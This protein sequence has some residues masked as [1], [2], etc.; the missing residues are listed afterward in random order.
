MAVNRIIG[1]HYGIGPAFLYRDFKGLQIDFPERPLRNNRI[2]LISHL[3]LAVAGIMLHGG[4]GAALHNTPDI[5][6]R[7]FT[8]QQWIFGKIFK[9]PSVERIS[10]DINAGPQKGV[11][12]IAKKFFSFHD[13][14]LFHKRCI[15]STG[16]QGSDGYLGS[17]CPHIHADAGRT[18]RSRSH[19]N[20]IVILQGFAQSAE[21]GSHTGRYPRT[22]H[23]FSAYNRRQF[24]RRQLCKEGFHRLISFQNIP[25]L[26]FTVSRSCKRGRHIVA[27]A[28]L[29]GYGP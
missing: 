1:C 12:L 3:F 6:R 26:D 27:N 22:A 14:K 29:Q 28:F 19:R 24:F 20:S 5:S 11:Y 9:I 7:H 17:L 15:E 18:V 23:A 16:Q 8:G 13:I 10:V 25:Q 4:V 21:A 2:H